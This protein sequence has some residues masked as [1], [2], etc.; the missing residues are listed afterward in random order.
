MNKQTRGLGRGLDALLRTTETDYEKMEKEAGE[1]IRILNVDEIIANKFQPRVEF[2]DDALEDLMESIKQFGVLQP[3]LVRRLNKGYELIAG[4]RRLRAS[5]L[6]GLDTIPAII[7][8]YTD[9]EITAIALIEN[10][11]REDL[12]AIEEA[13]AY[14]KLLTE[15]GL[16]QEELA[17]KVGRSRSHIA[18]FIRLLNLPSKIQ[19][20]VSRGTLSMGQVRPL[21]SIEDEKLQ[22]DTAEYIISEELS[23][24]AVEDFVRKLLATSQSEEAREDKEQITPKK[25]LFV[26]EAEDKLKMLLGTQVK[27]KPGKGKSKIEIEFYSTDDLDRIIETLTETTKPK[28]VNSIEKL[29]V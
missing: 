2:N 6:A 4:E 15:F 25:E 10:L 16:T 14:S 23:A 13:L 26:M 3:I 17:Q 5:K 12:T 20:Y 27:I 28:V 22:L 11:Q 9:T 24:R 21:I 1:K 19:Q 18:N 8:E 7:R 29:S